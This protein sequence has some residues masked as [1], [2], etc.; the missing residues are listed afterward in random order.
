MTPYL[1]INVS[2]K[3]FRL[4]SHDDLHV[5][6]GSQGAE[7]HV[8]SWMLHLSDGSSGWSAGKT[9]L[10]S[11]KSWSERAWSVHCPDSPQVTLCKLP[12]GEHGCRIGLICGHSAVLVAVA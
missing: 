7:L 1:H 12:F 4:R 8:E 3:S 9:S 2:G 10:Y 5:A 6:I 11:A